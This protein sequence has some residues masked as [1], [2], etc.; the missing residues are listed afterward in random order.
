MSGTDYSM[1][2]QWF[3]FIELVYALYLGFWRHT[4]EYLSLI[5]N[6]FYLCICYVTAVGK[7]LSRD[8]GRVWYRLGQ[9][10]RRL[11]T[12][13]RFI[14]LTCFMM[15]SATSA[16]TSSSMKKRLSMQ[17]LCPPPSSSKV[18]KSS[19]IQSSLQ[20]VKDASV[21][22]TIGFGDDLLMRIFWKLLQLQRCE[23]PRWRRS[24]RKRRWRTKLAMGNW[25][26]IHSAQ[27]N[28]LHTG[29]SSGP[30]FGCH[31]WWDYY[32]IQ[33]ATVTQHHIHS[34]PLGSLCYNVKGYLCRSQIA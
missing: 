13:W 16:T 14:L 31:R 34:K 17:V 2:P 28:V 23:R 10:K 30:S 9:H 26:T 29:L 11:L 12:Q 1:V 27:L 6:Y 25:M 19:A 32:F 15:A 7:N 5:F 4:I 33:E 18:V 3:Y 20:V 24:N 8:C 21:D 22:D